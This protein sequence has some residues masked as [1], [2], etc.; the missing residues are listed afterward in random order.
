MRAPASQEREQ[1]APLGV[2]DDSE[3]A[4]SILGEGTREDPLGLNAELRVLR[5]RTLLPLLELRFQSEWSMLG[6]RSL[7]GIDAWM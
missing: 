2:L 3:H 1:K 4:A 6:T 7:V 5:R